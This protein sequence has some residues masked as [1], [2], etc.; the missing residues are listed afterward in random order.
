MMI[1]IQLI[2]L[3]IKFN[4]ARI[5]MDK[6]TVPFVSMLTMRAWQIV[7]LF[8]RRIVLHSNCS[9]IRFY[10]LSGHFYRVNCAYANRQ[11]HS[12]SQPIK[13]ACQKFTRDT[14]ATSLGIG[15]NIQLGTA[16]IWTLVLHVKRRSRA[17]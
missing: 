17:N 12:F 11:K 5:S 14:T 10:F 8:C 7:I 9:K 4:L 16:C 1:L 6:A 13:S 3:K 2:T 15:R